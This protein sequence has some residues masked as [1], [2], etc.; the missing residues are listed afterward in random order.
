MYNHVIQ[1]AQLSLVLE[2]AQV[3]FEKVA[4]LIG[5]IEKAFVTPELFLFIRNSRAFSFNVFFRVS[6]SLYRG[7]YSSPLGLVTF[8]TLLCLIFSFYSLM[9]FLPASSRGHLSF[10]WNCFI[11]LTNFLQTQSFWLS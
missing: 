1:Y 5:D 2:S 8:L 4:N 7:L 3:I 11:C 9:S 10:Q 6:R